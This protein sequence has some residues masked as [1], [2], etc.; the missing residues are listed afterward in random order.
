M[1]SIGLFL[2]SLLFIPAANAQLFEIDKY[3]EA[4]LT[5]GFKYFNYGDIKDGT[6]WKDTGLK[7]IEFIDIEGTRQGGRRGMA[8]FYSSTVGEGLI[9]VEHNRYS[10]SYSSIS[11]PGRKNLN[12][13]SA[14][15]AH[16]QNIR[17]SY[18]NIVTTLSSQQWPEYNEISAKFRSIDKNTN[19]QKIG[20]VWS[21]DGE[22]KNQTCS[23]RAYTA[24]TKDIIKIRSENM[25]ST[26][27]VRNY[28]ITQPLPNCI[29]YTEDVLTALDSLE[30][31]VSGIPSEKPRRLPEVHKGP[32]GL[33][34]HL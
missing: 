23:L 10:N 6:A 5:W 15:N 24:S 33:S 7:D 16:E 13:N 28:E 22:R 30:Q 1:K 34:K 3:C 18:R 8:V 2:V 11:C 9:E 21:L 29:A 20:F 32:P 12:Y 19:G 26:K 27:G 17:T 25:L 14:I 31:L 4:E